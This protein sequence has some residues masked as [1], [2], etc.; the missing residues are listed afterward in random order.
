[1]MLYTVSSGTTLE[2]SIAKSFWWVYGDMSMIVNN[3]LTME[4]NGCMYAVNCVQH[5]P[6]FQNRS[7]VFYTKYPGLTCCTML[8]FEA[9]DTTL[10]I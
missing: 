8:H 7:D 10:S 1:M 3:S 9:I 2:A 4:T 6:C 5:A